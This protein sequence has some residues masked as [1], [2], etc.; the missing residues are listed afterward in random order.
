[1]RRTIGASNGLPSRHIGRVVDSSAIAAEW[2]P[3]LNFLLT[4]NNAEELSCLESLQRGGLTNV[5]PI[6]GCPTIFRQLDVAVLDTEKAL[7]PGD[8]VAVSGSQGFL[9]VL[10][11]E[12]DKHHTVFVTNRCS[13]NCIMCSQPPT[14]HEDRWL[15]DEGLKVGR[16]IRKSP[17]VVGF[18]G[19]EPL[20][21]GRDLRILLDEMLT[22]HPDCL[23]EVLTNGRGF[24]N[25]ELANSILQDLPP[26]V[27][28]MVP[29][30][31]HADFLHDFVVQTPGAFD[32]TIAGLLALQDHQQVIQIRLVLVNEVL[33]EIEAIVEFICRNLPFVANVALMG[34]EPTGFAL[35]NRS[36][37]ETDYADWHQSLTA[38][39]SRLVDAGI[40]PIIMNIPLC[41]LPRHLWSH[42]AHSISDWKRVYVEECRSCSVA[43][44]CCG[45]FASHE[46]GWR[47]GRLSPI[48]EEVVNEPI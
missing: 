10:Y 27:S 32:E 26:R 6:T 46:K 33:T 21:A 17:A 43:D 8:V 40:R 11:R 13:S 14:S 47:P 22:G 35:A 36:S 16:H 1:M 20:L 44:R 9:H 34:C 2:V 48:R 19:G 15:V 31:G 37:C 12:E 42:A 5:A 18:T 29:L 38:A 45:L 23:V 28:W 41:V 24:A 39:S 25:P 4:V 3:D 7:L 30:Y